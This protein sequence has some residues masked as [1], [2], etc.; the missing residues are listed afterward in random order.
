MALG[1]RYKANQALN[2][3]KAR[4]RMGDY[5]FWLPAAEVPAGIPIGPL[6]YP[7]RYDVLIRKS[8]FDFYA[9]H[10]EL[11][12]TDFRRFLEIASGHQYFEWFTRVLMVRF[13]TN[14]S[15]NRER[16]LALF[17]DR[18]HAAASLHDS[19]EQDGFDPAHPIIPYTGL[20]I[21]PAESGIDTGEKY[22]LGDGCHRLACLMSLGYE[23]LP[24]EFMRVKCFR[25]LTPL[26]NTNLLTGYLEI[27]WPAAMTDGDTG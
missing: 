7:L 6:V 18:L 27:N 9:E 24:R 5:W 11:Y 19:M 4:M 13:E 1:L 17:A 14:S 12:R 25:K 20:E 2:A 26:D 8:Y 15:G 3:V 16:T 23:T 22:F 10:R 21:L